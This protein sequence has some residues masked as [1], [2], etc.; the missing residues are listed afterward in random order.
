MRRMIGIVALLALGAACQIGSGSGGDDDDGSGLACTE[1]GCEHQISVAASSPLGRVFSVEL[2][3]DG[4]TA[5]VACDIPEDAVGVLGEVTGPSTLFVECL[6]DGILIY[7]HPEELTVRF[8]DEDGTVLGEAALT[9]DYDAVT[10]NGE[11]CEPL[12]YQG[13]A[14][15]Q[16]TAAANPTS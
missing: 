8:L 7:D 1:I 2:T 16:T 3:L 5:S 14:V 15:V 12:C 13:D 6:P 10:P 9:P 4:A 11:E